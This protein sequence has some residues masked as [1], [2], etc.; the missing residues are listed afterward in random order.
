LGISYLYE[1][2]KRVRILL[3]EYGHGWEPSMP[4][5][6]TSEWSWWALYGHRVLQLSRRRYSKNQN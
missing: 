5:L 1:I 3:C 2:Q 6:K 4:Y